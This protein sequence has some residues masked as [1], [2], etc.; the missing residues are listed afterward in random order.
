M[1]IS[2]IKMLKHLKRAE[3]LEYRRIFHAVP[4]PLPP[5]G[6]GRTCLPWARFIL[7]LSGTKRILFAQN[8]IMNDRIFHPGEVL[9]CH[10]RG[11]SIEA[12]DRE[13]SMISVVFRERYI[14][15]LYIHHNGLPPAQNGPDIFFHTKFPLNTSGTHTLRAI[16]TAA[17]D[18]RTTRLN[19]RALLGTVT[20]ALELEKEEDGTFGKEALT[21]E[22]I[23]DYMEIHS[24]EH[25]SREKIARAIRIHPAHLSRLVQKMTGLGVNEYLTKLRMEQAVSLL[26]NDLLSIDEIADCCGYTYSNYFIRVFRKYFAESPARYREKLRKEKTSGPS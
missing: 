22:C 1:E 16:L 21:W 13:H 14:R 17:P 12:W 3:T 7:P 19:F 11:W 8:G 15:V 18:S 24:L 6:D 9:F 5:S 2:R 4:H 20:E 10:A 23:Q 25:I 26:D